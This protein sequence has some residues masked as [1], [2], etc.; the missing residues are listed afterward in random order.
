MILPAVDFC[1]C[2]IRS[3]E[4]STEKFTRQKQDAEKYLSLV[5]FRSEAFSQSEQRVR[6]RLADLKIDL[7]LATEHGEAPDTAQVSQIHAHIELL[8]SRLRPSIF[9]A[10]G[11]VD[12]YS[13]QSVAAD[14][15]RFALSIAERR[16]SHDDQG[17][18]MLILLAKRFLESPEARS[19]AFACQERILGRSGVVFEDVGEIIDRAKHL[20][21]QL[22][23]D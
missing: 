6:S 8:E 15:A 9:D 14:L 10:V 19:E 16:I 11:E 23:K 12:K 21:V 3:M 2:I 17:F 13:L 7:W 1:F 22:W 5:R 4:E 20:V 18:D